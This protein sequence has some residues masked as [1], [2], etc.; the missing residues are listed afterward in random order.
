MT[1]SLWKDLVSPFKGD[2]NTSPSVQLTKDSNETIIAFP[3]DGL[4][5]VHEDITKAAANTVGIQYGKSLEWGVEWPDVPSDKPGKINY[6]GLLDINKPDTLTY[7][8]HNGA[9]QFWHSMAP[10]DVQY[11]NGEVLNKI[12]SQ[13]G[14]WY[15]NAQIERITNQYDHNNG[16]A[17]F[18]LGRLL[19]MVQDSY[20]PA[21]V[22]RDEN[23]AVVSFQAYDKQD[24]S[25]HKHGEAKE[26][27]EMGRDPL[28]Q[29]Q[30]Q[31]QTWQEVPGAMAA[32]RASVKIMQMYKDNASPE[33]LKAFLR[34][35][36]YKFQNEQTQ[37]KPA[38][39]IDPKYA[40]KVKTQ[41]VDAAAESS[42]KYTQM[43][44]AYLEKTPEEAVAAYPDLVHIH[45][46]KAA[47]S[48]QLDDISD[49]SKSQILSS[50]DRVA[51]KEILQ[52]NITPIETNVTMAESTSHAATL[53]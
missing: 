27:V 12:V 39:E 7:E 26:W 22:I 10:S 3:I 52:G 50:F 32:F 16:A 45:A 49:K 38:G 15:K 8:S 46:K 29:V 6:P 43:V 51:V 48:T 1:S 23:G 42:G 30:M 20:S 17:L 19:H 53:G 25:T 5:G 14:D 28:G 40:P 36:V 35:D 9:Y 47:V 33:E 31:Q 37:Y 13:A 34:E 18:Q 4:G 21:H 11:T 41:I 44:K 24:H 2:V